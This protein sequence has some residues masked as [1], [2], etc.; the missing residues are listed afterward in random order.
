MLIACKYEEIY[1]PEIKEF[2]YVTDKAYSKEEIIDMEGKLLSLVQFNLV[3]NSPFRFLERYGRLAGLD[4]RGFNLA[5]YLLELSLVEYKMLK[6]IPS[7]MACSTIYLVNKILKR[8]GWPELMIRS[9][10]YLE[11]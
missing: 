4:E 7:V 1:P 9:T 8:E 11:S 10:K 5:K 6:F 3:T 2:E